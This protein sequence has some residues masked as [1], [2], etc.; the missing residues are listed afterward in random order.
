MYW[1]VLFALL[2]PLLLV[3]PFARRIVR[4]GVA[5]CCF[6]LLWHGTSSLSLQ[7]PPFVLGVVL[8]FELEGLQHL[9]ERWRRRSWLNLP[10]KS[11][12]AVS[13][14]CL[15]TIDRWLAYTRATLTLVVLGACLA[16]IG[17]I[18]L[19]SWSKFLGSKPLQ[20]LGQRAFSLYLVHEPLVVALVFLVGAALPPWLFIIVAASASLSACSL[21]FRYIESPSHRFARGA[22]IRCAALF[23]SPDRRDLVAGASADQ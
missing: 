17:A 14:I 6:W 3:L 9:A 2:L 23:S 7:I 13:C 5:L 19:V 18:V 21:L 8:A 10:L 1:I 20:W 16:V 12:L 4:L 11:L 22:G 15:L